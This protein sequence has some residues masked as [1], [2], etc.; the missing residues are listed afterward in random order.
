MGAHSAAGGVGAVAFIVLRLLGAHEI[1]AIVGSCI[2]FLVAQS[3]FFTARER[4]SLKARIETVIDERD[5]LKDQVQ[6]LEQ[7]L[8]ALEHERN[9]LK[10]ELVYTEWELETAQQLHK[11]AEHKLK[12]HAIE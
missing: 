10:N 9:D 2:A 1:G 11:I 6:K 5:K 4:D 3:Y 8:E 7:S 12:Q